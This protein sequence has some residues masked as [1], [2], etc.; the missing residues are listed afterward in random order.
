MS[1]DRQRENG[2]ITNPSASRGVAS[3]LRARRL[4][5]PAIALALL[6]VEDRK[7]PHERLGVRRL[8]EAFLQPA[9]GLRE[10]SEPLEVVA[11]GRVRGPVIRLDID[12]ALKGADPF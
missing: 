3:A 1:I 2:P 12:R 7:P 11:H 9:A 5:L 8:R 10:R 6:R 4:V